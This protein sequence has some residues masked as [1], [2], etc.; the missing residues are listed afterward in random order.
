M[1]NLKFL[2]PLLAL[3]VL[4]SSF[5]L[6]SGAEKTAIISTQIKNLDDRLGS[7]D[8]VVIDDLLYPIDVFG[9]I[10]V[11][12]NPVITDVQHAPSNTSLGYVG[13]VYYS[14]GSLYANLDITIPS[15]TFNYTGIMY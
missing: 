3:I 6:K 1:R 12:G 13:S 2:F 8:L 5:T 10:D 7:F 15:G 4:T 11:W 14:S 9:Y